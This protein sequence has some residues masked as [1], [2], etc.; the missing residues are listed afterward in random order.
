MPVS[1]FLEDLVSHL[2]AVQL[3]AEMGYEYITPNEALDQRGSRFG[4]VVLEDVLAKQLPKFNKIEFRGKKR[5][6]SNKNIEL[7]IDALTR[8]PFDGLIKT[9][10]QIYDLLTLGKALEQTIEG[11]KRS[12]TLNYIDWENPCL[13]YTSPSPRD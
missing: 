9:N 2:P 7:A 4:R 5:A 10:E 11:N 6:F 3:L 1:E 12:Y 13:L 8:V